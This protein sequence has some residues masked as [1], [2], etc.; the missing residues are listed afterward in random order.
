MTGYPSCDGDW[1][2]YLV[3]SRKPGGDSREPWSVHQDVFVYDKKERADALGRIW[4]A[5]GIHA[6]ES[7]LYAVTLLRLMRRNV[8]KYEHR[9]VCMSITRET[10]VVDDAQFGPGWTAS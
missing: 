4:Q 8:T 2:V 7:L 9:L 1:K 3:Q 10:K 6:T 5:S